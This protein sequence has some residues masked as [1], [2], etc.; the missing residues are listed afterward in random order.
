MVQKLLIRSLHVYRALFRP[1]IFDAGLV[2][3]NLDFLKVDL[4]HGRRHRVSLQ[5]KYVIA[6]TCD[7]L[8][9]L[10][11]VNDS[12]PRVVEDILPLFVECFILQV[13]QQLRKRLVGLVLNLQQPDLV[14]CRVAL[15]NLQVWA[16]QHLFDQRVIL[17]LMLLNLHELDLLNQYRQHL[18]AN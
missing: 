9:V 11:A 12:V 5:P 16:S 4:F 13:L 15:L 18:G 6:R 7:L 10:F 3:L 14:A 2:D 17:F 1:D 8:D